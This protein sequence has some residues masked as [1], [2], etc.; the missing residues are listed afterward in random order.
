[1]EQIVEPITLTEIK[2]LVAFFRANTVPNEP[3]VLNTGAIALNPKK[4]IR[5]HLNFIISQRKKGMAKP[6]YNR[7][8]QIRQVLEDNKNETEHKN[9]NS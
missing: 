2:A 5:T 6:Y 3:M 8:L 4:M 7:L 9:A 1:M